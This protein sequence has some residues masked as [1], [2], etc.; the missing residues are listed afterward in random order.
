[1]AVPPRSQAS[2]ASH[3]VGLSRTP[4][5]VGQNGGMTPVEISGTNEAEALLRML[6]AQIADKRRSK[7]RGTSDSVRNIAR[8]SSILFLVVILLAAWFVLGRIQSN[9]SDQSEKGRPALRL[10]SE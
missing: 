2:P 5:G 8:F 7:R 4:T 6:D 3:S 1:M 10:P 9:L